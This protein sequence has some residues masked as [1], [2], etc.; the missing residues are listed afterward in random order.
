[1]KKPLS[2]GAK[3][4]AAG[5]RAILLGVYPDHHA[6]LQRAADIELRS[7][8]NFVLATALQAAFM[9]I[10]RDARE[11]QEKPK[12]AGRRKGVRS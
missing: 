11:K 2:G 5:K 7:L 12:A 3:L 1:M 9:V 6:T 8:S 4:K 10:E